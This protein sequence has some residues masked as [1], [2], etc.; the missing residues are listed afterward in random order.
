VTCRAAVPCPVLCCA[1]LRRDEMCRAVLSVTSVA[2]AAKRACV[3]WIAVRMTGRLHTR[4]TL[5]LQRVG[6]VER[7]GRCASKT[8]TRAARTRVHEPRCHS[9]LCRCGA[10]P[11]RDKGEVAL[12]CADSQVK[13]Q[14]TTNYTRQCQVASPVVSVCLCSRLRGPAPA[15]I[16]CPGDCSPRGDGLASLDVLSRRALPCAHSESCMAQ[17]H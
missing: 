12:A 11:C 13:N 14:R 3:G 10:L 8:R 1:V 6:A 17:L 2:Y 5:L 9:P 4:L 16:G 15:A 7:S